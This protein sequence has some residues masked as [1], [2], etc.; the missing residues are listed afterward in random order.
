MRGAVDPASLEE[1]FER[2]NALVAEGRD[3]EARAVYVELLG[4]DP[5]HLGALNNLGTLLYRTGLRRA[6]HTAFAEAVRRH[7]DSSMAHGNLASVLLDE[8]DVAGARGHYEDALRLDP[9]NAQAH[10]SLAVLLL[11]LGDTGGARHHARRGFGTEVSTW[12]YRG[13]G[14]PVRV[15]VLFSA[16]GGN[17]GVEQFLDDRV[18]QKLTL[19]AEF[20]D[21]G[22]EIPPHDLVF[23][24]I[25][26]ADRCG[27]ALRTA[28]T[29]LE[30]TDAP[31]VNL[32]QRV[33]AT[34]RCENA[35]RLGTLEDVVAPRVALVK[36]DRLERG[37][38]AAVEAAGIGWPLLLRSPGF[39][40]GQHFTRIDGPAGLP[41]ALEELPGDEL[42]AMEYLDARGVDGKT[43]K[44]RAMIVDGALYPLHLAISTQWKVHYFT[45]DMEEY[46]DHRAEEARFLEAM[47]DVLG[48]RAMTGLERIREALGLEY[49]GIDFAL[50]AEG[51]VL[52]FEANATM[53]VLRPPADERWAYRHRPV[54]RIHEAIRQMMRERCLIRKTGARSAR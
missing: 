15:L 41:E 23:N 25:G 10:Q 24:A 1:T 46:P 27:V 43:R 26:D 42:L 52:V 21:S 31:V 20:Y 51:R 48:P 19:V 40:T 44:Y 53:V 47:P 45:A 36:R 29:I 11:R 28:A 12:P 54:E 22:V 4:C 8:G 13:E 2:A 5:G 30:R 6:A 9:E 35:A 33:L 3:L 49:G 17:V 18:Y 7:P 16:L 14:E 39:H 50:D 32:P 37:D 34:R 38:L